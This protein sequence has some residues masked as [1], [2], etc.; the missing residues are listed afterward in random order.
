MSFQ[1]G[2]SLRKTGSIFIVIVQARDDV[3][4]VCFAVL[5]ARDRRSVLDPRLNQILVWNEIM[6]DVFVFFNNVKMLS[7]WISTACGKVN[8]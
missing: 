3:S 1:G 2:G 4:V 7:I 5:F 8:T 6:R